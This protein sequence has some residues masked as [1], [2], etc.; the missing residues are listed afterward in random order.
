[1]Q[2]RKVF[3]TEKDFLNKANPSMQLEICKDPH[4][5]IVG[6]YPTLIDISLTYDEN[7]PIIWLVPQLEDFCEYCG[8]KEKFSKFQYKQCATIIAQYFGYLKITEIMLFFYKLKAGCFGRMYGVVDPLIITTSL[9]SFLEEM[10]YEYEKHENL[11]RE[12]IYKKEKEESLSYNEY[13]E[14]HKK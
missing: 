10:A 13:C 4:K 1:M 2:I 9:H 12:E 7:T 11:V 8:C 3:G 5:C 6:S 14:R